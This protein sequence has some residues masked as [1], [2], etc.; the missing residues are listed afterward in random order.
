[1]NIEEAITM[2]IEYEKQVE[3]VYTEF[4]GTFESSVANK[5][6][7]TLAQEERDHLAFLEEKLVEWKLSGKI[8]FESLSSVVPDMERIEDKVKSLKSVTGGKSSSKE[9]ECFEK[10][11]K[12]EK[13]TSQFYRELVSKLAVEVQPMFKRFLEIEEAHEAI[14][15]AEIDNAK[16]MGFYFDFMEFDQEA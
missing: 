1:M 16:G 15:K 13:K 8:N 6:F 2:A 7:T 3:A 4:A 5:I 9:I 10:A 11:H 14:V 12:V